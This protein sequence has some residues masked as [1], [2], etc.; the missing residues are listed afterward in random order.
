MSAIIVASTPNAVFPTHPIPTT[1]TDPT[2]PAS[3]PANTGQFWT[4]N[5]DARLLENLPLP[6]D[7]VLGLIILYCIRTKSGRDF[8]EACFKK[9]CDVLQTTLGHLAQASTANIVTAYANPVL[10][11]NIL[12]HNYMIQ[13]AGAGGFATGLD[14]VVLGAESESLITGILG[15]K[16]FDIPSTLILAGVGVPEGSTSGDIAEMLR[17]AKGTGES[18]KRNI[19]TKPHAAKVEIPP[20]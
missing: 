9:Y 17:A 4:A 14:L 7:Y 5:H 11:A 10:M 1:P 8:L 15:G 3:A 6:P 18:G 19:D 13:A 12:E 2:N 16:G 20:P